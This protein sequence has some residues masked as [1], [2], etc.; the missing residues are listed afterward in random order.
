VERWRPLIAVIWQTALSSFTGCDVLR[1][2]AWHR[3]YIFQ[4]LQLCDHSYHLTLRWSL[5]SHINFAAM[6]A[7]N[8][9]EILAFLAFLIGAA[10][11]NGV[12]R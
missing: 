9:L 4:S 5:S 1:S 6:R 10:G 11:T 8:T 2:Q 3:N 12:F 7:I